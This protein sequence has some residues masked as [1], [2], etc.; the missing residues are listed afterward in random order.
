MRVVMVTPYPPKPDGIGEHTRMLVHALS[1]FDDVGVDVLTL[2]RPAPD[3]PE[4]HVHRSLSVAPWAAWATMRMLRRARPDIVHIQFAVPALG[5]S[6][7]GA[8]VA[9]AWVRRTCGTRLV[10]TLH[11][12]RR[13]LDL[14]RGVGRGVYRF[15][16][17]LADVVVVHTSEARDLVVREC[18][19][20]PDAVVLTPLGAEPPVDELVESAVLADVRSRHGLT[21]RPVAL[22]FGYLHP[23]KGI[24][25]LVEAVERLRSRSLS[26][27]DDF[28][29]VIAGAVRPRS[30][31]FRLF[32]LKDR[33]YESELRESVQAA[34][35][36]D[37]VR[38][39]GFVPRDDVPALFTLARTVVMPC[40][41][42]TQ[43][44][45]L[46]SVIAAGTPVIA[47]DLP[48]LRETLGDAGILVQPGHPD[49][50]AD[51]LSAVVSDDRF[52][53]ELR[54]R[55]RRRSDAIS[56][57]TVAASLRDVYGDLVGECPGVPPPRSKLAV[58]GG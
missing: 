57:A 13:E 38:F 3:R 15:L 11:E 27:A 19:A 20:H 6:G 2:R 1:S 22:C 23:D 52:A 26:G 55:A 24:E 44:S 49:E 51:A 25:H 39:V 10:I 42:V 53:S 7:L 21:N 36:S 48:G 56:L 32:G 5:L 58:G 46:G 31:V 34:G 28:D 35:L 47:S 40:R 17:A 29:V 50:I 33:A 30:G 14:L 4:P 37:Q 9:G 43:S 8:V 18:G 12:V 16:V 45:V 41:K 54:G